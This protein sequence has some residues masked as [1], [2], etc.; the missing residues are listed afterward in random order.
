MGQDQEE[1]TIREL[2]QQLRRD[3]ESCAPSFLGSLIPAQSRHERGARLRLVWPATAAI[4]V[5]LSLGGAWLILSGR[6]TKTPD[7]ANVVNSDGAPAPHVEAPPPDPKPSSIGWLTVKP[8]RQHRKQRRARV[9]PETLL[10]SH[11]RSPTES[12][13][14]TPGEQLLKT[15]PRLNES[16][17]EV[18]LIAPTQRQIQQKDR[19]N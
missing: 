7:P 15:I 9:L 17:I 19:Q 14:R 6:D 16:I 3:D 2:F 11:W 18:K 8:G 13:M 10:L 12:L 4:V 1:R 5:A